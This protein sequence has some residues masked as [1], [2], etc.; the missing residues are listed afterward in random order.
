MG[1]SEPHLEGE[2]HGKRWRNHQHLSGSCPLCGDF[3]H[4]GSPFHICLEGPTQWWILVLDSWWGGGPFYF[5]LIWFTI[6][7]SLRRC[8][9]GAISHVTFILRRASWHPRPPKLHSNERSTLLLL[10]GHHRKIES[11][12]SQWYI[13]DME[14]PCSSVVRDQQTS[15]WADN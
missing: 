12:L 5:L 2:F 13:T 7:R 14:I 15:P 10:H 8:H 3:G 9:R 11:I 6:N 1:G 4:L